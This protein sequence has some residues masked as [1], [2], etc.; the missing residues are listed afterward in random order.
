[1]PERQR[2]TNRQSFGSARKL[3]S[4]RWQARYVD[5]AGRPMNAPTTFAT[6]REALDHLAAVQADRLRGSYIDHRSG[7]QLFGPYAA[8][9]IDGGGSRGKLAPRTE[10][11]YRDI[12]RRQFEALAAMP[13]NSITGPT[14]RIWYAATRRTLAAAA[15]KRGATGETRLRQAYALLRAILTTAANDRLI[16]ENPCR[17]V[18]AGVASSPERPHMTGETF[19]RILAEHPEHLRPLLVLTFGAHLRLGELIALERRDLDLDSGTLVVE[20]QTVTVGGEHIT[21]PTKTGNARTVALPASIVAAMREHLAGRGNAFGRAPLFVQADGRGYSRAQVQRAWKKATKALGL[22]QFH[23]H[24]IRHAG[25]TAAAQAGATTREL[26]QRGGHRS[27]TVALTYQHAAEERGRIIAAGIDAALGA[28]SESGYGT[29]LART[30]TDA[31]PL[32]PAEGDES[33]R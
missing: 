25:L 26:M 30:A 33:G 5:E 16:A 10:E 6:K 29:Q 2:K 8:A 11:T 3:P 7:A 22:E 12:N 24:D 13:L 18:G 14:V 4:G 23:V 17:I 27:A 15:S 19:A 21:T 31:L 20:R 28:S 32:R 1:M 9:W